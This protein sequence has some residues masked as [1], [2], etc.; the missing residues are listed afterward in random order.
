MVS[1]IEYRSL[2]LQAMSRM[3]DHR[4]SGTPHHRVPNRL[5]EYIPSPQNRAKVDKAK[6]SFRA[7]MMQGL[8][9][10][11]ANLFYDIQITGKENVP[12]D[13]PVV[14]VANHVTIIDWMILIG[15]LPRPVISFVM[16]YKYYQIPILRHYL[17]RAQS[18]P[19]AGQKENNKIFERFFDI[20]RENLKTMSVMIF[21]EGK[22]ST[23]GGMDRFRKT[24][25][26]R[27][28]QESPV[29]VVPVALR[30][31]WESGFS[32]RKDE[33][34]YSRW[35][36]FFRPVVQF[37]NRE[38]RRRPTVWVNIGQPISPDEAKAEVLEEAVRHLLSNTEA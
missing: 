32:K 14:F 31:L 25:V 7:R 4:W 8:V 9:K 16:Y 29:P 27:I 19:I 36:A 24:G 37:F 11:A 3:V 10:G 13:M 15:A 35:P 28:L 26:E 1:P 6:V 34:D 30:G 5:D 22:L 33:K 17:R 18:V 38:H 2:F 21:P 20:I 23:D 12:P